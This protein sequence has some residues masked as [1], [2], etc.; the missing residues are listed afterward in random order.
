[1]STPALYQ[2]ASV[3]CPNCRHRFSTPVLTIVDVGQNPELKPLFLSG[4]VNIAICPQ[5]GSGGMLGTPIVY[6]DPDKEMLF[7]YAPPALGRG[8][9]DQQRVLG[10]L[11][12]RVMMALPPEKRKGYLL[13]P[14]NFM[15]L[16][17]MVEAILEADGITP[18]MMAAQRARLEL[19]ERLMLASSEEARR[20][21]AQENDAQIDQGFFELL[22]INLQMARSG[23]QADAAQQL[24]ALRRQLL[25]WTTVGRE[26]AAREEAIRKLG[27][28][29]TREGLLD[30]V[31]EAS[32]AGEEIQVE[33]MVT[34]GRQAIDYTFYALLTQRIESAEGAG[35]REKATKLKGLRETIL[36]LT[37]RID[38]QLQQA[39]AE[40]AEDLEQIVNSEDPQAEMRANPG[41][42][43][44]FFLSALT[45]RLAAAE[46]EGQADRAAKLRRVSEAVVAMV[47]E[48]QPPEVQFINELLAAEYPAGT[49]ALLEENRPLVEARL[50]EYMRLV[51]E[52]LS[53]SGR[54]E[55]A[56]RL[57]LVKE[58]ATQMV[59]TVT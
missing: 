3:S 59:P 5:C 30:K 27:G 23:E 25:D 44:Q 56:Q 15:R 45:S 18:E 57:A 40:A 4:Q 31:I 16:E 47:Q 12:N 32:L 53:T 26:I 9:T 41:M 55:L 10:D 28:T 24:L 20:V 52:E 39:A 46:R 33:T 50:L 7:T 38:A 2:T 8:D 11:T 14:R 36:E 48:S 22:T 37:A 42:V 43:D 29:I 13:R 49:L 51:G 21:I 19:L 35:D 34:V 54:T 6:H 1:M 58:Q 17:T